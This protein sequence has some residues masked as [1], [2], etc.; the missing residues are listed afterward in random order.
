MMAAWMVYAMVISALIGLAAVAAV[1]A[2]VLFLLFRE[3]SRP[4]EETAKFLPADT[5]VY[6][7]I[8]LRPG[9][10]QIMDARG[11]IAIVQTDDFL[12]RRDDLLDDFEDE[13][14]I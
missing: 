2:V 6:L 4:G 14:G 3:V 9:V 10:G 13:T 12:D 1:V 8:N 7:S 5:Q 11:F